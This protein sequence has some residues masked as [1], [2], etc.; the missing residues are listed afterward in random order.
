MIAS[1]IYGENGVYIIHYCVRNRCTIS[2]IWF[3]SLVESG[4]YLRNH[5]MK[6]FI[7]CKIDHITES[8]TIVQCMIKSDELQRFG[9]GG[10]HGHENVYG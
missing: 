9:R 4:T 1:R 7:S 6:V 10:A 2:T 3:K 8:I 5:T